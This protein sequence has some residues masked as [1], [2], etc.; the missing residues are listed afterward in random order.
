[1]LDMLLALA[2][3]AAEPSFACDKAHSQIEHLI[4]GSAPL[5]ELDREEARL[6]RQILAAHPA[7]RA[8]IVARQRDFLRGRNE[9]GDSSTGSSIGPHL[10]VH[11]FYLQDITELRRTWPVP[12][13]AGGLSSTP[14]RYHCDGGFPDAWVTRFD[15][16][17]PEIY[18]SVHTTLDEAMILI[19]DGA[20]YVGRDNNMD[21]F[22][23]A[24]SRLQIGRRICT[25]AR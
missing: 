25:P 14:L 2:A 9:C 16:A 7:D 18:V 11:D 13:E 23:P 15:L 1:M 3:Q 10:C 21:G 19:G 6:Y 8:R 22:D 20:R 4:C 5:S 12:D 24:T 17:P